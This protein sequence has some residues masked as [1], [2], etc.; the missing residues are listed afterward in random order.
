MKKLLLALFGMTVIFPTI[1]A[2]S[3][4]INALR[5]HCKSGEDVTIL[6]DENPVVRFNDLNLVISS[7]KNEISFPS[8]Q[9][10]KLTYLNVG[11]DGI[12][13]VEMPDV[14]FSFGK[15]SLNIMNLDPLTSVSIYTVDGRLVSSGVTD[16][17][18]C[19]TL[20]LPGQSVAVYIVH[21]PNVSFKL[22]R[23]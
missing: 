4:E 23:P 16:D 5:I 11:S 21:T 14:I 7:E 10:L 20:S 2:F 17:H 19:A 18:G 22:R 12:S 6:L 13:S 15:Q 1:R 3:S 9:A 8:D